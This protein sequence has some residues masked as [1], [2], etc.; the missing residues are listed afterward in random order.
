MIRISKVPQVPMAFQAVQLEAGFAIDTRRGN[1][2]FLGYL[3]GG[4]RWF[5]HMGVPPNGR[6]VLEH[7]IKMDDLVVPPF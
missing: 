2:W 6:F 1:A 7:P 4:F 3:Y 5:Q